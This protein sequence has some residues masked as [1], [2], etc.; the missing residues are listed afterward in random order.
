MGIERFDIDVTV[1]GF[2][3]NL[4]TLPGTVWNRGAQQCYAPDLKYLRSELQAY[5]SNYR[6]SPTIWV[7]NLGKAYVG[8]N[9]NDR[10]FTKVD[11][12]WEGRPQAPEDLWETL[13]HFFGEEYVNEVR[14][15][16]EM[17]SIRIFGEVTRTYREN[18]DWRFARKVLRLKTPKSLVVNL[19]ADYGK[20]SSCL[21]TSELLTSIG[22]DEQKAR[23]LMV[24]IA[25][26][27][28]SESEFRKALGLCGT[29]ISELPHSRPLSRRL[30]VPIKVDY[31]LEYV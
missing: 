29:D 14:G 31:Q 2:I 18:D 6:G 27:S 9:P 13:V 23:E 11:G 24:K 3:I 26:G 25:H 22:F 28:L 16:Q 8:Y 21:I 17:K 30:P 19:I 4:K 12:K 5:L 15:K 10:A 7:T 1:V 20:Y